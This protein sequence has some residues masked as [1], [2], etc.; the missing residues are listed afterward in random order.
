MAFKD[1][2]LFLEEGDSGYQYA[3]GGFT[4]SVPV[5]DH[6]EL[7]CCPNICSPGNIPPWRALCWCRAGP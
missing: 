1:I 5:Q 6:Q 2:D 3:Q 4:L 7:I